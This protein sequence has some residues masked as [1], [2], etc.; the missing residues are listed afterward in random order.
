V[1]LTQ[2]QRAIVRRRTGPSGGPEQSAGEL[3]IIPLIDVTVNMIVFLLVLGASAL[4]VA[5]VAV[6]LPERGPRRTARP[7]DLH[8]VLTEGG[9]VVAGNGG[10]LAPGCETTVGGE[11]MTVPLRHGAHD[12]AALSTCAA[13]IKA[14]F[15]DEDEVTVTADA[16]VP[17][18]DV[19]HAMDALRNRGSRVLFPDVRL[20]AGLR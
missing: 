5:Q 13:R 1:K 10:K 11:V 7:L 17:Y 19:I 12:F 9:I 20:S 15:P 4:A 3:N 16:T 2:A 18:A 8:V 6:E 14:E